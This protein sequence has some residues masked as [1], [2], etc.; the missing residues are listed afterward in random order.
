VHDAAYGTD[1]TNAD[2]PGSR[3]QSAVDLSEQAQR[4]RQR[5]DPNEAVPHRADVK[6]NKLL[7]FTSN[8]D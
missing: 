1:P 5:V 3:S 8:P 7:G 6:A 4:E 2:A